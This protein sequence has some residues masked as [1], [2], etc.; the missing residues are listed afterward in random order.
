MVENERAARARRAA[1]ADMIAEARREIENEKKERQKA[2]SVR[3]FFLGNPGVK[4]KVRQLKDGSTAI[5]PIAKGKF[6]KAIKIS[7]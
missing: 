4:G 7:T 2:A 1:G 5:Q 6:Q 3:H